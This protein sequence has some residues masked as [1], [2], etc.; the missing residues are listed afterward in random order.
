M[1]LG[2]DPEA[3]KG[4]SESKMKRELPKTFA[5]LRQFEGTKDRPLRGT[6]RGTALYKQYFDSTDPFYSMYNIG[7]YTLS[8]WKVVWPEVGH[9]VRAGVCGPRQFEA[10]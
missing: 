6:V 10:K 1:I 2:Q 3:G 8:P 4:I 9:T 5:D 7:P